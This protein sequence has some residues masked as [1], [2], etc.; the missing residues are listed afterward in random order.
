L[1]A[2]Y[3]KW[4]HEGLEIVGINFDPKAETGQKRCKTLGITYPQ[5]WVP[6]DDKT[7]QLWQEASGIGGVPHLLLIDREGILRAD[8]HVEDLENTLAA[9]VKRNAGTS[10]NKKP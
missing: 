5:V 2:L 8:G 7:R 9:L 6:S 1:E 4:H 3:K 10:S